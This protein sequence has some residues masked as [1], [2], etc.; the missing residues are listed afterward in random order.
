MFVLGVASIAEEIIL[1]TYYPAPY[2]AYNELTT[3]GNTYLATTSG[4]VGIGT[5]NPQRPFHVQSSTTP[6]IAIFK[7]TGSFNACINLDAPSGYKAAYEFWRNGSFVNSIYTHETDNS[8][9]FY[10]NLDDRVTITSSGSVGIGVT[11]P[12]AYMLNVN[13][14]A[15]VTRIYTRQATQAHG[16]GHNFQD[17]AEYINVRLED[18][19]ES[20]D[21]VSID[22][23]AD[24]TV[25]RSS[26]EYDLSLAG[27][28]S[29]EDSAAFIIGKDKESGL[30]KKLL[31]LAGR[32]LIKATT[33]NGPIK[34]G[35]LLTSSSVP[36]H[37]MKATRPGPIVGKALEN[38]EDGEG[39]IMVL[40]NLGWYGRTE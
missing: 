27:I 33:I 4:R 40:V 6:N 17:I 37:A 13:G 20:G 18:N 1:T 19:L 32:V 2:G 35:D 30:N 36:G 3:T 5:T 9:R 25:R 7:G 29:S 10:L 8:M 21:V 39:K 34:R 16:Q 24:A 26:K 14:D 12:G 38:L 23:E 22:T 31:A 11:N 28:I 15:L